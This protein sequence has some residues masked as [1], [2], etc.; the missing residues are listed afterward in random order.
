[1]P[2]FRA[3]QVPDHECEWRQAVARVRIDLEQA[4]AMHSRNV[5]VS[6]AKVLDLLNPNGMWRYIDASTEPMGKVTDDTEELDPITGCKPVTAPVTG[7]D[8]VQAA[9]NEARGGPAP[10]Q[11][12]GYA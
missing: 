12:R 6:A 5:A 1:M 7:L 11:M 4:Q 9:V 3:R 2:R 10:P 8:R